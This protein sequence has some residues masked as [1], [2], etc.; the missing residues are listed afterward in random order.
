M[1]VEEFGVGDLRVGRR[2]RRN[3]SGGDA[4]VE[5]RSPRPGTLKELARLEHGMKRAEHQEQE[6]PEPEKPELGADLQPD[7]VRFV[8]RLGASLRIPGLELTRADARQ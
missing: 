7:V 2:T 3:S 8:P 6:H 4:A 1:R 5:A